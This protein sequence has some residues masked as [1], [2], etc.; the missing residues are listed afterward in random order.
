MHSNIVYILNN[1][2]TEWFNIILNR[3]KKEIDFRL[4]YRKWLF[5]R[6]IRILIQQTLWKWWASMSVGESLGTGKELVPFFLLFLFPFPSPRPWMTS[7]SQQRSLRYV[8]FQIWHLILQTPKLALIQEAFQSH[9]QQE[10]INIPPPSW[11]NWQPHAAQEVQEQNGFAGREDGDTVGLET[12]LQELLI[13]DHIPYPVP[14]CQWRSQT[15][16]G[17]LAR[18][19]R[20]A[21]HTENAQ[22]PAG[23]T[24]GLLRKT[25][26]TKLSQPPHG[27]RWGS[28]YKL[29][30]D[31]ILK[32][33]LRGH[34]GDNEVR[35]GGFHDHC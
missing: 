22:L 35:P 24:G 17:L 10:T 2:I 18:G 13:Q 33:S 26:P 5:D 29:I 8:L 25:T 27:N 32:R 28:V 12:E 4:P 23:R 20:M 1:T 11:D 3:R 31:F 30:L 9:R 34:K 6:G 16:Q 14:G 21:A 7:S 15:L 19:Q